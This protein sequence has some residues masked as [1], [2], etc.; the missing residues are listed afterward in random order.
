MILTYLDI[1]QSFAKGVLRIL[2]W[3]FKAYSDVNLPKGELDRFPPKF[4]T[5][6][7]PHTHISDIG[8]MMLF[9]SYF[10]LPTVTF[11][12]SKKYFNAFTRPWLSWAGAIPVNTSKGAK[13]NL[14][15]HLVE[16]AQKAERLILHIPPS[17]TRKKTDFW[18]SGFYHIALQAQ[19][20]VIPAYLDSATKTFGYGEPIYMSGNVKADMDKI[21]AFYMDKRGQVPENESVIKLAAELASAPAPDLQALAVN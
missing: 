12:V 9:F 21:R 19:I 13:N 10:R 2:G 18:R 14:V 15:A 4:I 5:F 8:L 11:P 1:R 3:R 17:G 20:P 7:E 16:K 6:G